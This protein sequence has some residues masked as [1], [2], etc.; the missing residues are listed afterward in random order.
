MEIS[1]KVEGN[2]AEVS[3][4]GRLDTNAAVE[5]EKVMMEILTPELK[6]LVI[7]LLDCGYMAS[8]GLRIVVKAQKVMDANQGTL[9]LKNVCG[10]VME[11][12]HMTGLAELLTFE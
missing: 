8:S 5:V 11:V 6:S 9:V 1:K 12:F 3:I 2:S 10:D 4:K 7:D